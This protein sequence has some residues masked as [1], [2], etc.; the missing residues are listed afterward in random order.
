MRRIVTIQSMGTGCQVMGVAG[1][2]VIPI[3]YAKEVEYPASKQHLASK[4]KLI[5]S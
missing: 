3:N 5:I 1:C 4:G 2:L